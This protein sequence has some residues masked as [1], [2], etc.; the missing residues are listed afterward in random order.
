MAPLDYT[1]RAAL[2]AV[3]FSVC[4][5]NLLC[6]SCQ[7]D[8]LVYN[9]GAEIGTG[10]LLIAMLATSRRAILLT[11]L[12]WNWLRMRYFSPDAATYHAIVSS[13]LF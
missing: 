11:V 13:K 3:V 8:A 5:L 12:Y 4:M 1:A 6:P 9:A 10:F 2:P 7:R